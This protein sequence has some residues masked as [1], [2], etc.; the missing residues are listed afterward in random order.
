VT[1]RISIWND[2][3]PHDRRRQVELALEQARFEAARAQRQFD[4]VDPG[5]RL[6]TGELERRWNER[7]AAV[8]QLQVD[9]ERLDAER[10]PVMTPQRRQALLDL[11]TELPRAWEHPNASNESR[12]RILRAVI[13]EI[14]VHVAN[15]QLE[16]KVHWQGGDHTELGVVKNRSG[17]HRWTTD[18]EV[19][20][21]L[22]ELA[23][24]LPDSG[25]ASLLNRL[26]H[27]TGKGH[28]WTEVSVRSFRGS[29]HVAVYRKGEREERGE[30]TLEQAAE[31]LQTSKMTVLRMIGAGTLVARQV[32]KGAPWVI[33]RSDLARPEAYRGARPGS[34]G[35]QTVDPNQISLQFQ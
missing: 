19:A 20:Q 10:V 13:K 3:E 23:R 31:V 6:V 14:V 15:A 2:E 29:H 11:G 25:I 4:A 16:L 26:G 34:N 33:K 24:L 5:N 27:R 1:G 28:T 7:L 9:L 32:C 22:P 18:I 12:K 21:L 8:A 17:G 35:P 30:L